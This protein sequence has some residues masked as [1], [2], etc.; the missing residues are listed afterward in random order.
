MGEYKEFIIKII[1]VLLMSAVKF[2]FGYPLAQK[3]HFSTWLTMLCMIGGGMLGVIFYL[4]LWDGLVRMKRRFFPRKP[5]PVKFTRFKRKLVHII[6][7]YEVWGVA[8]LSPTIISLPIGTILASSFEHNKWRIKKI[9]FISIAL[10][11]VFLN[12]L[13]GL[14]QSLWNSIASHF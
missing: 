12:T 8:F 14:L 4:Y 2:P 3:F 5:K 9:M 13:G 7:K 1:S 11:A 10:W 6:K